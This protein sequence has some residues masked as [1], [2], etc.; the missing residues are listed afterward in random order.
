MNTTY[1]QTVASTTD[2]LKASSNAENK[3]QQAGLKVREFFGSKEALRAVKKQFEADAII[4]ALDKK[5]QGYLALEIER[6]DKSEQ[7]EANRK[8]KATARGF[9]ASYFSKIESHAFPKAKAEPKE[10]SD[11]EKQAQ[12]LLSYKQQ[13]IAQAKR[14]QKLE[15]AD[16]NILEAVKAYEVYLRIIG[17]TSL[18]MADETE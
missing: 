6:G 3:L 14:T 1:A 16:F 4:P 7:A 5:Y 10:L 8:N 13:A 2:A 12:A 17:V 15:T 11:E 18:D 9:V